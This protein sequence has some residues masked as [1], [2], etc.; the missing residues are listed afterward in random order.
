MAGPSRYKFSPSQCQNIVRI[1]TQATQHIADETGLHLSL[2]Q[3]SL[4]VRPSTELPQRADGSPISPSD[5]PML[6]FYDGIGQPSR[7]FLFNEPIA[8]SA[9]R[10]S[11]DALGEVLAALRR[12]TQTSS[13][14]AQQA[15]ATKPA[16]QDAS[17]QTAP[18]TP[19][20][21]VI[22]PQD[23]AAAAPSPITKPRV[24]T[25]EPQGTAAKTPQEA[26][27]PEQKSSKEQRRAERKARKANETPEERKQRRAE[28]KARKEAKKAEQPKSASPAPIAKPQGA[29]APTPITKPQAPT[30]T[31]ESA[32]TK[33]PQGAPAPEQKSSKE[34]RRAERQARRAN[35]TPAEKE[36][37]RAER[38]ARKEAKKAPQPAAPLPKLT[39][40]VPPSPKPASPILKAPSPA[41]KPDKVPRSL[42]SIF[43]KPA[44]EPLPP[45]PPPRSKALKKVQFADL[46][47]DETKEEKPQEGAR[48]PLDP[49]AALAA[50]D[51]AIKEHED[52]AEKPRAPAAPSVSLPQPSPRKRQAPLPPPRKSVIPADGATGSGLRTDEELRIPEIPTIPGEAKPYVL[53]P[54]RWA[55]LTSSRRMIVLSMRE[56][57]KKA[58]E[59]HNAAKNATLRAVKV[60]QMKRALDVIKEKMN[61]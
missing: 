13:A 14:A 37:R 39:L 51:S 6:S 25:E 53:D 48:Q 8:S 43:E 49:S 61:S 19:R 12:D 41:P 54:R 32:V 35:E 22:E 44:P 5:L 23:A 26:P 3:L 40:L 20:I 56:N 18:I 45:S 42:I 52:R 1:L 55:R 57:M 27:A 46:A 9:R 60:A 36:Q 34:Q 4:N 16:T 38:K 10:G 7:D 50:L 30:K 33:A 47:P 58:L 11:R 21:P 15:V 24:P 31:P 59:Q 2:S 17:V 28:R 29:A